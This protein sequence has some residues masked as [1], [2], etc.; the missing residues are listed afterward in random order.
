[1]RLDDPFDQTLLE[2]VCPNDWTNPT[3]SGRYNLVVVGAGTA[4]LIAASGAAGLGARVALIERA[5]LGGDCLNVGCVP[6]KALLR[7]AHAAAEARQIKELGITTEGPVKADFQSV[8]SRLRSIR[9]R[10]A[11]HDS[12]QRYRE[13]LGVDVYQGDARFVSS[14]TV[15][16][17]G[18]PLQFKKAVIAT[19]ARAF[20]PPIPGLDAIEFLTNENV[21][22]LQECPQRLIVLGGGP[23][24]CELAQ[25]F[26]RLGAQVTLIEATKQFLGREDPDAAALLHTSLQ[27]DGI[28]IKLDT[29]LAE[30]RP[31]QGTHH[32]VIEHG[33]SQSE[34]AFD[35][36]LVAV[37]RK[38]NVANLGLET[39]GVEYDEQR[40]V[41]VDDFLQTRN[42][43]IYAAGDVCMQHKFTHAAD[44][45]AR[46]VIQNALFS[47]GP[48]GR[49]RLS[50]LTIPW[51]TYTD[52]E[53]AHVGLYER[54][55]VEQGI[56]IDTY[57]RDFSEIDRSIT[58]SRTQGFVKV[59]TRQGKDTIL[60]AT[61]VAHSAGDMISEISVAMAAGMGLGALGNVI[62][63]YPTNAGALA[64]LG[65]DYSRTRLTPAVKTFFERFLAWRR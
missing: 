29:R 20:V 19:G 40:G 6:S 31:G 33:E 4:G 51:C 49:R 18:T 35:Q 54:D 42:Q 10:I 7:S 53:I 56:A 12:A 59:H 21:F 37:G 28:D 34:M 30:I 25:S 44:F 26:Q 55:A 64:Q 41:H 62:H 11:P 15:D 46:A 23:I 17:A 45:A 14:D 52:P 16:V 61:I 58:E 24:G 3:P 36:I 9:A 27:Q 60:G 43:N 48:I 8:M 38:P 2:H 50:S 22:D 32:A 65:S 47:I 5:A 57:V 1:M 63:P 13:E 39:V